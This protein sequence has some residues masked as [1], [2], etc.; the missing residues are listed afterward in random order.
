[1]R[2]M[3]KRFSLNFFTRNFSNFSNLYFDLS[4]SKIRNHTSII[5]TIITSVG[6]INI[7][8]FPG[9]KHHFLIG[10]QKHV[11]RTKLKK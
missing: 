1:M 6:A 4:Y 10:L 5:K 8:A 9:E 7:K 2:E 3:L 11:R